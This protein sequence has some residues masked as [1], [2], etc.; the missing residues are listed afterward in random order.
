MAQA[1]PLDANGKPYNRGLL[2]ATVIIGTFAT[3]LTQTLLAT[4]YPTLMKAFDISTATVQWLTTGFLLVN[5]IMIPISA[6]LLNRFSTKYLYI[7]AM[8][9]FFIGTWIC[10]QAPN[11][12]LLLTGR[13]VEAVGVGLSMPLMQT[14]ALSIFPPERRGAAM[15]AVGLA[16]GLAPAIGPT[17]SGW[18]IDTYSWRVLF[19]MILPIAGIVIVA[20]FFTMR[21]VLDTKKSSLDILSAILSTI[22]FGSL[23]Y[24]FSEVGTEGWGSM[25]VILGIVI[26]IIFIGLFAW[27]QLVSEH[28]FLELHVFKT[29]AF[30]I[31]TILSGVVNMAMVGAE[32]VL[33]M[34]IQTV[35]GE[36][37]FNSGLT[38][39]PG[40]IMMGVMSPITGR[41]FDRFGAR[42]LAITGM[43]LLT[44][45]TIPFI[46]L[47]KST[48]MINV[49]ILYA[50]RMF[51]IAMV[52]MP[53]TTSGM[54]ALPLNLISHGTAV[55]NTLRQV[56]S[57]VGTAILISVLTNVTTN[58]M[59]AKHVLHNTPLQYKDHAMNAVVSGYKSAFIV[60]ALFCIIGLFVTFFVH[61]KKAPS[62]TGG[63]K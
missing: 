55:N 27:R 20:S 41:L 40:A 28:P 16:I 19:S 43:T 51:G 44:I 47:T 25:I 24:G 10:W 22:G 7:S 33:P 13:L 52:M 17:L 35:R 1:Q 11:F 63:D 30:T 58:N 56:A 60:A 5:G 2:L 26:G 45:G 59:P 9:I 57:S 38:L 15:G 53:V 3:V 21:K 36:T 29:P 48:P 37:A 50:I 32:M 12:T 54:N 61:D 18:V 42:H 14:I 6:W 46:F 34:Y 8:T 39:L 49:I 23:L 4:A 62:I 31:A